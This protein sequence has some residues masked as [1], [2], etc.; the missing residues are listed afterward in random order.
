MMQGSHDASLFLGKKNPQTMTVEGVQEPARG[1][2]IPNPQAM[3]E[4]E[5]G[6]KK[7]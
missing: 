6:T 4:G 5:T 3:A 1:K 7:G 2:K